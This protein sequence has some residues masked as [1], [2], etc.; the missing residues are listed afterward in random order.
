MQLWS[1]DNQ[2][3]DHFYQIRPGRRAGE[4]YRIFWSLGG[5]MK[6]PY[7]TPDLQVFSHPKMDKGNGTATVL[8][9]KGLFLF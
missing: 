2:E 5:D 1:G 4:G 6:N 9:I 3:D 7:L 8:G